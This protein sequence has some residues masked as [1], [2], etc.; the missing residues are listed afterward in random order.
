[1]TIDRS[2][3][4]WRQGRAGVVIFAT[5]LV[6][7]NLFDPMQN[8]AW[9]PILANRP[10]LNQ[11]NLKDLGDN[12]GQ[13]TLLGV[14]GGFRNI[15]A[16]FAWVRRNTYWE[17]RDLPNTE[18][19]INLATTLDPQML[20]FW[21]DGSRQI[22]YDIPA[23]FKY[24]RPRPTTDAD[25]KLFAEEYAKIDHDQA[26]RG[27]E[28]L[29]RGLHFLPNNFKLLLDKA[30]IYQNRL[31][32]EPGA[33]EEAAEQYEL[34]AAATNQFYFPMRQAIRILWAL[35][36]KPHQFEAY[37]YLKSR[38]PTLPEDAPDAQKNR[39]WDTIQGMEAALK[40]PD[41][42]ATHFPKPAHYSSDPE[43]EP[44]PSLDVPGS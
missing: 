42:S 23:W 19:M 31:A 8:K 7:G 6:A 14:F 41:A 9:N 17:Q 22:A 25:K 40:I 12:L 21:D 36:D 37:D 3:W 1:M 32:D 34:T 20:V 38:Y 13:G 30:E 2:S 33:L 26:M 39:M 43:F 24:E 29:D 44:L 16:D 4:W 35:G 10:E 5:L 15:L 28:F 27:L 18:A 11:L